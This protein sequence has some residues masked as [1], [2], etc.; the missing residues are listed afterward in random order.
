MN[1]YFTSKPTRPIY[2]NFYI[3]YLLSKN[4]VGCGMSD[5]DNYNRVGD[6]VGDRVGEGHREKSSQL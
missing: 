6:R 5:G 2:F 4:Q 1:L 3:F